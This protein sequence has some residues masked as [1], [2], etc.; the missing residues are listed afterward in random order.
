VG[1]NLGITLALGVLIAI[2][3]VIIAGPLFSG[4][5]ARW[6]NVHAPATFVTERERALTGG[7][8]GT[9]AAPATGGGDAPEDRIDEEL[10]GRRPSF[11]VTLATVLLPVVLM[12][13]KALVDI[14]LDEGQ[15][16][17]TVLDFL[18]TPMIALLLSVL[19]AMFTFGRGSGMDLTG[20]AGSLEKSLP[21][22]AGIL[23]IVAAGGGFKQTLI[24]TGIG[25]EI[26]DAIRNS[27]ISV[28]VLAWLVAV[29]IRL[30]TGSATVA[31]VTAS[32]VLAPLAADLSTGQTSLLVLAIG[33]GSLF[34]SH[35]ND[36]GFW[37]VKE[38]FHVTVAQNLKTWSVME[39]IISV[40]GLV[41][42]LAVGLVI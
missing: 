27:S 1:A 39:T 41:F 25:T 7:G 24:D 34:F 5:A 10:P 37:L 8:P 26:A 42:V 23:L 4:V 15:A 33:S 22:I 30:A 38:Y 21:P 31:T 13:G 16:V 29:L 12:M 9:P 19:V 20:I 32:G 36:A 18:G 17:R 2:P 35:V 3:T 6:V 28:L 11:G 14:F 40:T